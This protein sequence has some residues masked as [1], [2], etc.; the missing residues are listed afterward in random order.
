[1]GQW[2]EVLVHRPDNLGSSIDVT[3]KQKR[4]ESWEWFSDLHMSGYMCTCMCT[5]PLAPPPQAQFLEPMT[6]CK[7]TQATLMFS[8]L[9]TW[10][11]NYTGKTNQGLWA[12]MTI[13]IQDGKSHVKE[14]PYT[15]PVQATAPILEYQ[16]CWDWEILQLGKKWWIVAYE[17]HTPQ[18]QAKDAR[19]KKN[20]LSSV[21]RLY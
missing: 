12:V 17:P 9:Y 5:H 18:C 6:S 7:A 16:L 2:V 10:L 14:N 13:I 15:Y 21:W 20:N 1:M 4:T 19:Y 11:G 8:S 3:R